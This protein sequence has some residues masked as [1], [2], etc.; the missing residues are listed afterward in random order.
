[1]V[2]DLTH[3]RKRRDCDV[4][5]VKMSP[6]SMKNP[7]LRERPTG[8][9]HTLLADHL[10]SSDLKIEKQDFKMCLVLLCAGTSIGDVMPVKSKSALHTDGAAGILWRRSGL[11][12]L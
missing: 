4:W 3:W 6:T 9:T 5:K 10:S 8:W 11:L 1:M 12:L 7:L 2:H